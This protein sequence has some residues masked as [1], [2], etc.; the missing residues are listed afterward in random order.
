MAC[1]PAYIV[2]SFT[3]A[4]LIFD[5]V[6]KSWIDLPYHAL[7]GILLT[8]LFWGLCLISPTLSAAVLVVP[9]FAFIVFFIGV[10][11]TIKSIK[12]KGCCLN[13]PSASGKSECAK[14][15]PVKKCVDPTALSATP[16]I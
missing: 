16:L 10:L 2:G 9:G 14:P 6:V 3:I 15:A 12:N 11:V 1:W 7:G 13:C 4:L 8:V 5:L